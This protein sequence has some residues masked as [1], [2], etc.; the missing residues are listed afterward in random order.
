M[1]LQEFARGDERLTAILKIGQPIVAGAQA[2]RGLVEAA[3]PTCALPWA[4]GDS[5]NYRH[6]TVGGLIVIGRLDEQSL[7]HS[8]SNVRR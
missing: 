7:L 3:V 1:P 5:G 8:P 6:S 4:S 2:R